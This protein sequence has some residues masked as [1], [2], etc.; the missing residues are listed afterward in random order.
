MSIRDYWDSYPIS[1]GE[2]RKKLF[3]RL[4][5]SDDFDIELDEDVEDEIAKAIDRAHLRRVAR[6]ITVYRIG[7]PGD[8]SAV[9]TPGGTPAPLVR[10]SFWQRLDE[11]TKSELLALGE[12][13]HI[14]EGENLFQ[15]GDES[16]CTYI[17]LSG[18][19]KVFS[20]P[21]CE[22]YEV[23]VALRGRGDIVGEVGA[24]C[25]TPRSTTAVVLQDLSALVIHADLFNALLMANPYVVKELENIANQRLKDSRNFELSLGKPGAQRLAC[26][27]LTIVERYGQH[28]SS[29]SRPAS[30]AYVPLSFEDVA[31]MAVVPELIV[32]D[33]M[34]LWSA[35]NIAQL[36]AG[37]FVS[38]LDRQLMRSIARG[39]CLQSAPRRMIQQRA[40]RNW[41]FDHASYA[42]EQF[43]ET[44]VKLLDELEHLPQVLSG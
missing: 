18:W 4:V 28:I 32:T 2:N 35:G 31:S 39:E 3:S 7:E 13:R 15:A 8:I 41:R 27:I 17:I 21:Q 40:C 9:N 25:G 19:V 16:S 24:L 33:I 1:D 6:T 20:Q 22:K 44:Q 5:G 23:T 14:R 26:I 42:W 12:V 10:G 30:R 29:D 43:R 34:K 11:V 37:S 38:V 36:D